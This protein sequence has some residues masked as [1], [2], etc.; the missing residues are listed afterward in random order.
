MT[1]NPINSQQEAEIL[2]NDQCVI[3]ESK[4]YAD[5]KSS[6]EQGNRQ[7]FDLL[8]AMVT[9]DATE[10]DE[11]HQASTEIK[12]SEPSL[13]RIFGTQ[14]KPIKGINNP[15]L[16]IRQNE[17][18][19]QG[20]FSDIRLQQC[21][22]PEPVSYNSDKIDNNVLTNLDINIQRKLNARTQKVQVEK[23]ASE[24]SNFKAAGHSDNDAN[25]ANIHGI[26]RPNSMDIDAWFCVIKE[27][28]S[29]DLV[30]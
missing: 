15:T 8:L 3:R 10:F 7:N 12:F 27:A 30:S 20:N 1:P 11:F 28:R 16:S 2:S 26:S 22:T 14:L 4:F 23:G 25:Y 17:Q 6:V 29:L 18:L 24:Q 9:K 19:H 21:L 13:Q 5:L